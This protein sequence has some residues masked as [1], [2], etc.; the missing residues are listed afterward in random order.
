MS[1][2]S[3][4]G[5]TDGETLPHLAAA[6]GG[7]GT[8]G[9]G[10]AL[11]VCDALTDAGVDVAACDM[12]GTSAGAWVA[13][14]LATGVGFTDLCEIPQIRVPDQTPGLLQGIA[15]TL[16]GEAYDARVTASVVRLPTTRRVLLNGADHRLADIVA[17]SSAVPGLFRPARIGAASYVDGGVRS[18][19]SAHHAAPAEHLLVVAPIAG[20]MFGPTGRAMELMLR[21]EIG[22]WQNATGGTA[23]LIRPNGEIAALARHPLQLFDNQRAK[24]A[25]PLAYAQARDLLLSR[26][27][28]AQLLARPS[29][30]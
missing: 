5:E 26:P 17:A 7:G 6:F 1:A 8:F 13:A 14:C 29:A 10:Y 16:F 9:I 15:T 24:R 20:S 27:D 18:L 19:V 25:Y 12:L 21:R 30:A 2:V 4:A 3:S 28:L 11:G 22:R 23:H